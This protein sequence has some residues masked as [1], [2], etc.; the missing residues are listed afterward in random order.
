GRD[1]LLRARQ[2]RCE[3]IDVPGNECTR[4]LARTEMQRQGTAARF[5]R[6]DDRANAD[7][8]QELRKRR[9]HAR[10]RDLLHAAL[11][12]DHASR[13]IVRGDWLRS[14]RSGYRVH[15]MTWQQTAH[16]SAELCPKPQRA[17][18]GNHTHHPFAL[19]PF[20]PAA[21]Y[22]CIDLGVS[23]D[24]LATNFRQLTVRDPRRTRRFAGAACETAIEMLPCGDGRLVRLPHLFRE[25]DATPRP[26]EL[27]TE[28]TVRRTRCI[29]EA[30][31][32]ARAQNLVGATAGI[33]GEHFWCESSLHD[34]SSGYMRARFKIRAGSNAVLS[35]A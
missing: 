6:C 35:R 3:R 19:C 30:A 32:H 2:L 10:S 22:A 28:K 8:R 18:I 7:A 5:V 13:T 15:D 20:K 25:I 27:V 33:G 23:L 11:Q 4:A 1:D 17:G 31:M 12:H 34:Q 29:A 21:S 24:E 26:V 16:E 9:V 14:L